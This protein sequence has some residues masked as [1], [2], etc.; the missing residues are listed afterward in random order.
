MQHAS[1]NSRA[2]YPL[3][4]CFFS[5]SRSPFFLSR[6]P[7]G[8]HLNAPSAARSTEPGLE[9]REIGVIPAAAFALP[10]LVPCYERALLVERLVECYDNFRL[11]DD[12]LQSSSLCPLTTNARRQ[13]ILTYA[14][15]VASAHSFLPLAP[16][17]T[18]PSQSTPTLAAA[19]AA[20][21]QCVCSP[22][23]RPRTSSAA[24]GFT[25]SILHPALFTRR[26]ALPCSRIHLD[27]APH[28]ML[29]SLSSTPAHSC[30]DLHLVHLP[31]AS[32]LV[33]RWSDP[34]DP[35][36]PKIPVGLASIC[37]LFSYHLHC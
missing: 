32:L 19:H 35:Y 34:P 6:K 36:T 25:R 26:T 4:S 11:L 7:A 14:A 9:A 24:R 30:I 8:A 27:L 3:S 37:E 18:R 16:L 15:A 31:Y 17:H 20:S 1:A 33:L 5:S 28:M 21:C 23:A 13:H 29:A 22:A 10:C 2:G 12:S